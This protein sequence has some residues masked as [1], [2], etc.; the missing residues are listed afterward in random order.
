MPRMESKAVP[1]GNDP[2]F[3]QEEFRSGQPTLADVYRMFEQRFDQSDRYWYS[4]KIYFDQQ[5]KKL[6]DS[7]EMVDQRIATLERDAR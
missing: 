3:Q 4:I 2:V 5:E 1:E 6:D 7:M